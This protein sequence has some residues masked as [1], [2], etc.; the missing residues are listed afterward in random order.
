MKRI[1]QFTL[2]AIVIISVLW[3]VIPRGAGTGS[4][5][6]TGPAPAE[7][8]AYYFHRTARCVT[9]LKIEAQSHD[10]IFAGFGPA[11]REG[12]LLFIPTNVEVSGNEHFIKDYNLV[13]QALVLVKYDNGKVTAWRDLD[14][15]WDLV[16][17]D[18]EFT[19]YVQAEVGA[20]LGTTP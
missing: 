2:L 8:V 10:A 18:A 20:F 9:C 13:S 1:L 11:L 19:E 17:D 15:I 6:A 3:L 4:P 7:Y 16:G 5:A 14:R 12:R